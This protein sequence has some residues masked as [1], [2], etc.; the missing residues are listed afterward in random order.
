VS[1]RLIKKWTM[2]A[3]TPDI[4]R[5]RGDHFCS[6]NFH[7]YGSE[8]F[9][10][11]IMHFFSVFTLMTLVHV[12]IIIG[13]SFRVIQVRLPVATS[14]AWLILIFFLP[15]VGAIAYLVLGEKRLGRK[16]MAR[17]Q[18]IKGRYDSWLQDLPSEIRSDPQRLSPEA[19]S[20]SRL[21]ETAV[22]IPAL[23]GNRLQLL[24]AA[25]PILRS[26]I[27]DIDHAKRFCHLEFY[28]W[29]VGGMADEVGA[30]LL[31]AA[32]RGVTCRVLLDAIG[33]AN[34]LKGHLLEQLKAGGVEV[35]FA[36]PVSA[37]SVFKVRPDLR[38]HRKIVVIDDAAGYTGS[39]NLVDPRLFKQD[40]GVGEWVDAMVRL[41]GPGVLALNAL[42]RWDWEVE[43]GREL[44]VEVEGGD[45]STDLRTGE[46]DVQVIPSGPGKTGN[47]IY[48]LLLLTIYSARREVVITTPY[49]VPDEAVSTALLTAAER[50]VKVTVIMPE[51]NDSRLVHYTSRSY[52][53]D[54]LAAGIQIFG[55]KSG[56]LHT[57]SVVVDRQVALFGSVNMDVRSF[58]LDF[59]VTLGVYDPDFA[60]RLLALQE[61][62]IED[63]MP[64]D[65][66]TWQQRP[67]KERFIENLARLASPL[68]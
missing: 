21:A 36:L 10:E 35:A 18:A 23:S 40:A 15:L 20:L 48:Q 3:I 51:R 37:I 38:L 46:T 41:E 55:F 33:S 28:I 29:T 50:G 11:D 64:V 9:L 12:L 13:V 66:Q 57:K 4:S 17:T 60:K 65:L 25:E 24:D 44:N 7:P 43:T 30:A 52:F 61:K 42:F 67:G 47:S 22:N 2:M 5:V 6:E 26:M 32:G 16:F 56:L 27:N 54:M 39:F 68:L 63:S 1:V 19:R 59:E 31:R 34:F 58:W 53:D 62:Y 49:F 14:L 8:S 45:S